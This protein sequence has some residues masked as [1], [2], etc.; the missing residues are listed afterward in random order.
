MNKKS[1]LELLIFFFSLLL[2]P[3]IGLAVERTL[4]TYLGE[5]YT[6][7]IGLG[8]ALAIYTIL[9][10]GID[11]AA[12]SGDVEKIN[13]AKEKIIGAIAGLLLLV[14][15]F[16]ILQTLHT[17][18]EFKGTKPITSTVSPTTISGE[19]PQEN[20]STGEDL[21]PPGVSAD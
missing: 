17:S 16:L 21:L 15:T 3:G 10:A 18:G 5:F 9:S 6:W 1:H 12:S 13:Q 4:E 20:I 11:Y 8:G 2:W 19:T 7:S 14:L